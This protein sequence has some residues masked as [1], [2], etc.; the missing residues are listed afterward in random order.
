MQ[1]TAQMGGKFAIRDLGSAGGTFIRIAHGKRKE[2]H[3]G[4]M[5]LLGKH[6]FN[7]SSIDD[8]GP[9]STDRLPGSPGRRSSVSVSADPG[10]KGAA[11]STPRGDLKR[12]AID[13]LVSDAEQLV[14]DLALAGAKE[15]DELEKRLRDL[16]DR[17]SHVRRL[18]SE[19]VM[20]DDEEGSQP[21]TVTKNAR[22]RV[23][24][25]LACVYDPPSVCVC[26]C[27]RLRLLTYLVCHC[28]LEYIAQRSIA[29]V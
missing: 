11:G 5:I 2:L 29:P 24:L 20:D 21:G 25:Y 9:T 22:M 14:A 6:Q 28:R 19:L 23:L 13:A 3:P 4:M 17:L 12:M 10:A 16:N 1:I 18:D 7:V 27:V 15:G 26:A 8:T